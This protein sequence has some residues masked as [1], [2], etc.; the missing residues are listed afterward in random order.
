MD[1]QVGVGHLL[2][3]PFTVDHLTHMGFALGC[4]T[5]NQLIIICV[6]E[7]FGYLMGG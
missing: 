4:N 5:A 1:Q 3:G 7:N 6:V 2:L